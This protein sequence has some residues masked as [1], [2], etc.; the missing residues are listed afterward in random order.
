MLLAGLKIVIT[1]EV[2]SVIYQ[3]LKH[4]SSLCPTGTL[5]EMPQDI[6]CVQGKFMAALFETVGSNVMAHQ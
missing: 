2:K 1:F 4:A 6:P 3:N 5:V